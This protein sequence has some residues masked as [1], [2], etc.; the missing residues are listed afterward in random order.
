MPNSTAAA[1]LTTSSTRRIIST[2]P[3][4]SSRLS[5]LF[6]R[7]SPS[8]DRRDHGSGI[9]Y[10]QSWLGHLEALGTRVINGSKAFRYETSKALQTLPAP[11]ARLSRTR[12]PA[13][14]TIPKHA[15][16]AAEGLRFPWW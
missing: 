5:L 9:L 1:P 10:T 12:K 15:V 2:T 14:S 7:M 3:A 13:S 6:N 4:A 16:A 8:A 11:L